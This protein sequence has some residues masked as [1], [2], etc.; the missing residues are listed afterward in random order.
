M[1]LILTLARWEGW[2]L[3][4][5]FLGVVSWQMARGR[6][7]LK[8][9]LAAEPGMGTKNIEGQRPR[10]SAARIQSLLVTLATA[11]YVLFHAWTYPQAFPNVPMGLIAGFGGSQLWYLISKAISRRPQPMS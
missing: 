5:G 6:I 1:R 3:V 4:W 9:L 11:G 10:L 7:S 2:L 8:R